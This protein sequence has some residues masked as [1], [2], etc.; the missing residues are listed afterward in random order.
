[1]KL[2]DEA[3]DYLLFKGVSSIRKHQETVDI[4]LN[5]AFTSPMKRESDRMIIVTRAMFE[6]ALSQTLENERREGN[7]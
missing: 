7:K 1:M 4:V 5:Y 3:I 6:S 2:M